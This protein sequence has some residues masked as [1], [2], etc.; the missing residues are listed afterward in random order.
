MDGN[1]QG[2]PA[3]QPTI[4]DRLAKLESEVAALT[5]PEVNEPPSEP[6]GPSRAEWEGLKKKLDAAG[7][8]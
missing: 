7:I 6:A 5:A 1:Q 2:T 3:T 4:E 8:R